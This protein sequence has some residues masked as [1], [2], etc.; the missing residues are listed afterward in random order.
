MSRFG[1]IWYYSESSTTCDEW[2]HSS[3]NYTLWEAYIREATPRQI[4]LMPNRHWTVLCPLE[5]VIA[6]IV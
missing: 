5:L 2:N 6:V 4:I 3:H 1:S